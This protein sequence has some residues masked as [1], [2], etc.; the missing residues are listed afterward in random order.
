MI[1][2]NDFV[3][4]NGI[5]EKYTGRDS[6]VTIPDNVTSIGYKALENCTSLTSI[7]IPD[8]VTSI[9]NWAFKG[10]E[11]LTSIKLPNSVIYLGE[12]AFEN[13][14]ALTSIELP[15]SVTNIGYHAFYGC[16]KLTTIVIPDI[17]TRIGKGAFLDCTSLKSITIP[18]SVTYIGDEAFSG[19]TDC[20]VYIQG[21]IKIRKND[22]LGG[23]YSIVAPKV[24]I[25]IFKELKSMTPA[26]LG[27][28]SHRELYTD[29]EI[30]SAYKKYAFAQK[31][32][33]LIEIFKKDLPGVLDFYA[34]A[35]KININNFEKVFLIPAQNAKATQCA[36][37]LLDWKNKNIS[38]DDEM[39]YLEK[40]LNKDPYNAGDMKKLWSYD[41]NEDGTLYIKKYKGK[42]S[43][44]VIPERIGRKYVTKIGNC[45]FEDCTNLESITIPD[46]VTSIGKYAFAFCYC[47]TI[48][49]PAGSYADAYAKE[50]NIPF[51]AE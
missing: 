50:N 28:L 37:W 16:T 17:V 29:N 32:K 8:G 4:D 3:I 11:S 10:C 21:S 1:N 23:C 27:F 36:L 43:Y 42:E 35:R 20:T 2:S 9:E 6:A 18:D 22:T 24:S 51:V 41:K 47:F 7:T 13:C 33:I 39:K 44:V 26:I 31:K 49:A 15:Q 34:S 48:H 19:C 12:S 46:S 5:L 45:A 38:F 40:Q 30:A 14:K 25:E